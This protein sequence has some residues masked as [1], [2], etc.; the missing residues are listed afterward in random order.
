MK[1]TIEI[2]HSVLDDSGITFEQFQEAV[3]NALGTLHNPVTGKPI[4]FNGVQVTIIVD[5]PET[6]PA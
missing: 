2:D 1:G 4:Y 3:S 5:C 6:V